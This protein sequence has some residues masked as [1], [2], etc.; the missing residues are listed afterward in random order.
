MKF[1][2]LAKHLKNVNSRSGAWKTHT[3]ALWNQK[4]Q[5]YVVFTW[6]SMPTQQIH[7]FARQQSFSF[8]SWIINRHEL[9]INRRSQQRMSGKRLTVNDFFNFIFLVAGL[10]LNVQ[11]LQRTQI[12][13]LSSCVLPVARGKLWPSDHTL[14]SNLVV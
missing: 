4:S 6:P 14:F 5:Y 2:E 12:A 3:A 9:A 13:K 11:Q 10:T 8:K 7:S 1:R